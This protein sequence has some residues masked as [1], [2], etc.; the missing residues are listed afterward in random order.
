MRLF[1]RLIS[2]PAALGFVTPMV[3]Q[4][5]G[6]K[7]KDHHDHHGSHM[8][9]GDSYPS[10][11]FM[12]KTTFILGGVDGVSDSGMGGMGGMGGMSTADEK[13]G[14]VFHYDTKLMFMTSFTGQDMLK[15]AVRVGNFGMMEPFGMMGEARLDSAFSSSDSLAL[16]KAYYQFPVGD[17]I[18]VTFGPKLRQDDLLGVWPSAYTSDGVLF[19]LNQA[20]ASDT[21]SKKMGAGAGI[22]W[23]NEKLVASALFV[24]EDAS[25]SSIGF[26]ADEGK[27]HIT[28]QL[29]W[30]DER[31]TL[32]AAFTQS[33]NGRTDNSPDIN[34]YSSFA[35]SGSYQF[36]DDYSLSGGL[37]WKNPENDDSPDTSMNKVEDGNTWSIGFLWNNALIE[38]NKFGFGIGTAETHR[39]DSGYDDPL[40]WEAFYDFKVSDSV[41]VTP[42][43]FVIEKD[44]KEE[45]NGALVKTTFNF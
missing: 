1:V 34:D 40:A 42:A 8:N 13:D 25:I 22:T 37:G 35:I 7:H 19:V 9:M 6:E 27:D 33:D 43:I 38:G 11:M 28:T 44:G 26:L 20:G 36:G 17:D 5:G 3:V 12:G 10:T 32:A 18:Q 30:V 14:T 2:I 39:D 16:H 24:S 31:Y 23:S 21:Y 45:V 41:T 15:T 29:A 4:A